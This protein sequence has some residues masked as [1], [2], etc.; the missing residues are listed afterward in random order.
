MKKLFLLTCS[1]FIL[2]NA[3]QAKGADLSTPSATFATFVQ[4]VLDRDKKLAA[5]CFETE[6]QD[7]INEE[8][9]T[10]E[11][12]D[13]VVF[14]IVSEE[15]NEDGDQATCEISIWDDIAYE[16]I[17]ET[18]LFVK[19]EDGWKITYDLDYDD[20]YDVYDTTLEEEW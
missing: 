3:E 7:M 14:E 9:N 5:S 11:L 12:P 16:E 17:V 6:L 20:Y 2:S 13:S 15:I 8:W 18:L 10:D 4:A 19:E 1:L